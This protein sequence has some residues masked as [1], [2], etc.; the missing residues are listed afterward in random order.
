MILWLNQHNIFHEIIATASASH[1]G[2]S[3]VMFWSKEMPVP[4]E[5]P[6]AMFVCQQRIHDIWE[7]LPFLSF[8]DGQSL[9]LLCNDENCK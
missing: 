3:S 9:N 8:W 7:E 1:A 5:D 2:L 4:R 6:W